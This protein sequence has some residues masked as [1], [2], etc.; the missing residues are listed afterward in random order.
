[1]SPDDL[2][3]ED[4]DLGDSD[5]R[6]KDKKKKFDFEEF[7]FDY[8]VPIT[9]ILLGAILIGA[10]VLYAK[11]RYISNQDKIEV[12]EGTTEAQTQGSELVVEISGAI[13]KPGVYKLQ[14]GSRIE[15]LLIASGGLS[16]DADRDW[17]GKTINRASK[18]T[19]GQ[20]V[21][22]KANEHSD[23][24]SAKI[25]EGSNGSADV[26]GSGIETL[27][28]INTASTKELEDLPGIGPVYAQSIIEHRPYSSVEE[29]L[30]KDALKKSVYEKIKSSVGVY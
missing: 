18:L 3:L 14:N 26:R 12:I 21:Y 4:I 2:K 20:K 22:I 25:S 7:I 30:S 9:L 19:D 11:D 29:L 16:G 15:D 27:V 6:K 13:E 1:M 8:R 10:G 17:V 5:G 28:N 23:I 24:S